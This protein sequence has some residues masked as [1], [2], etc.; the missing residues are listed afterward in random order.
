MLLK[1]H[2]AR[3]VK[4]SFDLGFDIDLD[5]TEPKPLNLP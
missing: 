2:G 1:V 5:R 4:R 3:T